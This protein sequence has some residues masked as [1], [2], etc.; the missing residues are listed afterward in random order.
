MAQISQPPNTPP[1]SLDSDGNLQVDPI[2]ASF[3]NNIFVIL[4]AVTQSGTTANRP[5]KLL[6]VGRSYFDTSLG[7]RIDLKSVNPN[8]WV[9][10]SGTPV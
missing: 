5:T 1:V 8:V 3:F 10:G 6:W 2:W 4:T 7:K 9:D